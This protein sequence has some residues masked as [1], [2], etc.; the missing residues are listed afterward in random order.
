MSDLDEILE[1][2]A[3]RERNISKKN[4]N[5]SETWHYAYAKKEI[6]SNYLLKSEVKRYQI[7]LQAV[8]NKHYQGVK[9]QPK[10]G[11]W[12]TIDRNDLEFFEITSEDDDNFY[13]EPRTI[14]HSGT[15]KFPKD[16]FTDKDFGV[17]RCV[18]F[19]SQT[20]EIKKDLGL[21]QLESGQDE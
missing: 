14:G 17:H 19:E 18:I 12:Y 7:K 10:V 1:L 13:I 20:A 16:G 6:L 15:S 2:F 9:W 11:D 3:K 8:A 4:F 21:E 5:H